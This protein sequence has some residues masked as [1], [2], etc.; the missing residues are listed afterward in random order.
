MPKF[1][2]KNALFVFFSGRIL[3][4]YCH[5]WNQHLQ[6]Y[7]IW[8]FCE[9]TK[10]PK[11]GTEKALFRYFLARIFKSSCGIRIQP[12]QICQIPNF[13]EKAKWLKF[14]TKNYKL[15]SYLKSAPSN[16][17]NS[18]SSQENKITLTREQRSLILVFLG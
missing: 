7:E 11:F 10:K 14:R 5:T 4:H 8:K 12:P 3:K 13:C 9:K 1:G 6:I 15:L 2:S 18:K 16:F 17:L